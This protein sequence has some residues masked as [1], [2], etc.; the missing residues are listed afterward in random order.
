M[1][2][3]DEFNKYILQTCHIPRCF[4]AISLRLHMTAEVGEAVLE[5]L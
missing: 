5:L 1:L 3:D 2:L 4:G